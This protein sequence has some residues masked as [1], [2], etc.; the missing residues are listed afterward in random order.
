MPK[1]VPTIISK[2]LIVWVI[3]LLKTF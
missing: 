3:L 1:E 2:I